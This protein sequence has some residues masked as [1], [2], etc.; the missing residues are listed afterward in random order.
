LAV[1]RKVRVKVRSEPVGCRRSRKRVKL[2]PNE[3]E[4]FR[5]ELHSSFG[6][7]TCTGTTA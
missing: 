6:E 4:G 2:I 5:D 3:K 1:F 7:E